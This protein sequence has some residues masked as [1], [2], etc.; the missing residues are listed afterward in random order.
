ME[1]TPATQQ[2][3][4]ELMKLDRIELHHLEILTP[5]EK[6]QFLEEVH[7][8][9]PLLTG[10]EFDHYIEQTKA[11]MDNDE[12]WELNHT[13]IAIAIERYVGQYK[14]APSAAGLAALTNLTPKTIRKHMAMFRSS[15]VT[16]DQSDAIGMM[17][18]R[19]MA[20]LLDQ[21][22]K[23]DVRAGKAFLDVA[24]K[25]QAIQPAI[26]NQNNFMQINNTVINQQILQQLKPEQLKQ[27]EQIIAEVKVVK[28]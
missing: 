1:I 7:A 3:F 6:A 2:K 4:D 24:L 18:P 19:V 14:V 20:V 21:A 26:N 9:I 8:T 28:D 23:G 5:A 25:Q 12:I 15:P 27:I 11:L 16:K 17:I 22:V 13:R 10:K